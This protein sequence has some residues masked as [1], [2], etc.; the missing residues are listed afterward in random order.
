MISMTTRPA[1]R[2]HPAPRR[3]WRLAAGLAG[4][5]AGAVILAG[6]FLPWVETFA[7][8]IGIPGV[9]GSNG[10]ILAAAGI[11]IAVAGLWH[12]VRGGSRSR[13]LVGIGGFAALGFSGYL[14][15]QL[16]ATLRTLGGDSMVLAR[17]GP[18][19]WVSAGGSLLAFA[20][21]LPALVG[22]R[23]GGRRR[24]RGHRPCVPGQPGSGAQRAG[25]HG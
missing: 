7:G 24:R 11:L 17:G 16:A 13:W 15:I 12:A 21:P 1:T 25:P 4:A 6:A 9:R 10:R 19:L 5:A 18:G 22:R 23:A 2:P 14:L 20:H 8:L 3:N